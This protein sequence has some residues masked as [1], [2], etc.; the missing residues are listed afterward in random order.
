MDTGKG[1]M[2]SFFVLGFGVFVAGFLA[3]M[4]ALAIVPVS[5][6]TAA[7]SSLLFALGFISGLLLSGIAIITI[8]LR[9]LKEEP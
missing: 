1:F 7:V 2:T 3:G 8:R 9:K 6:D 4:L 5:G